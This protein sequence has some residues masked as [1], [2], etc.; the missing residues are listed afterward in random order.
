MEEI[1]EQ[2]HYEFINS[3]DF[4]QFMKE[5]FEYEEKEALYSDLNKL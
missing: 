5:M 4:F 1:F 3:E 2:Q